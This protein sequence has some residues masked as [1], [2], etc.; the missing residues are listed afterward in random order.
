MRGRL[1]IGILAPD[2]PHKGLH[3]DAELIAWALDEG[4]F[5]D[6]EI[7]HLKNIRV[8]YYQLDHQIQAPPQLGLL[9]KEL[10]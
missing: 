10:L 9:V 7:L 5:S 6:V 3:R 1:E 8:M 4:G 2:N